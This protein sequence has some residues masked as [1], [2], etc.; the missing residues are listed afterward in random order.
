MRKF[1]ILMSILLVLPVLAADRETFSVG[2][3]EVGTGINPLNGV[4]TAVAVSNAT[5]SGTSKITVLSMMTNSVV[6]GT[7]TVLD[8]TNLVFIKTD[9]TPYITNSIDPILTAP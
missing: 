2:T 9:E 7:F 8:G 5:F 3:L 6:V 1:A 4:S